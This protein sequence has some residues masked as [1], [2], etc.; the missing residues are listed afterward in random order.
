MV[1]TQTTKEKLEHL[2]KAW[3]KKGFIH[4][5]PNGAKLGLYITISV[6]KTETKFVMPATHTLTQKGDKE[7]I[8]GRF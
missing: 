8:K 6:D 1:K 5:F 7:S 2:G 4:R 3:P